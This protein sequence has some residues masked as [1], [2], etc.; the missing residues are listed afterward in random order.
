MK[1]KIA[2]FSLTSCEGCSLQI[3]NCEAEMPDLVAVLDFVNFREAMTEK[4][5]YYDIA[6]ID[7]ACSMESEIEHL[8]EIRQHAKMV[9]PIGNCACNGGTYYLKNYY[10]MDELLRTDYGE[11]ANQYNTIPAR[12]LSAVIP[13]TISF[14]DALSSRTNSYVLLGNS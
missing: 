9:I 3:L 1:P 4:S 8:K 14:R 10:P 13:L 12:P 11:Y 2:V 6:F 5:N 7:G